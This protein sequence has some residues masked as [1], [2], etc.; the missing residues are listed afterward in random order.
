MNECAE[1]W[2]LCLCGGYCIGRGVSSRR[3]ELRRGRYLGGSYAVVRD[4]EDAL[5]LGELVA[6]IERDAR[7]QI[8]VVV[9]VGIIRVPPVVVGHHQVDAGAAAARVS[10]RASLVAAALRLVGVALAVAGHAAPLLRRR[11]VGNRIGIGAGIGIGGADQVADDG[12]VAQDGRAVGEERRV[13]FEL[14]ALRRLGV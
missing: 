11:Q 13:P 12:T 4:G 10:H 7:I 1:D 14:G 5:L 6:G 3:Q 8:V 9:D 2:T